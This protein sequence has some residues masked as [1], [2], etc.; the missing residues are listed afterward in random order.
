VFKDK[1]IKDNPLIKKLK[2]KKRYKVPYKPLL[3][4]LAT[5]ILVIELSLSIPINSLSL[6]FYTFLPPF[7]SLLIRP[8][9]IKKKGLNITLVY[10]LSRRVLRYSH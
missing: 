6:V 4:I 9:L 5:L 7:K 10:N 8:T 1:L 2:G 3:G